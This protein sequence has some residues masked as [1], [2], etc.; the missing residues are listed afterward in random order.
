[1][2]GG[3]R[4]G[5]GDGARVLVRPDWVRLGGPLPATVQQVW[6]RGA[7][8]DYRL[9]TPGGEVDVRQAGPPNARR[10]ERLGWGLERVWMM[11][12]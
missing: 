6:Y 8:T 1:M 5:Q 7:H 3:G 11:P 12:P 10:G 9:E 2:Q 4:S